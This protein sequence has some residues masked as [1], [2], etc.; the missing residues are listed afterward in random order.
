M[1]RD[2]T[3]IQLND[4]HGYLDIHQELFWAGDHA[5]YRL[6]GGHGRIA[7]LLKRAREEKPG[8]TLA[9]DCGDT[10]HGTYPAVQTEGEA[11]IPILNALDFEAMTSHWEFAY[12]PARLQEIAAQLPYPLLA[13]NCYDQ[14]TDELVFEPYTVLEAGG[15]RIGVIGIAATIVDKVMPAAFSEG[16][17]FTLGNEE[18]P[19]H[20][21]R[22][23]SDEGA[24][25]VLVVSHLGF[26][27]EVKLARE[28]DGIDICLSGHAHSRIY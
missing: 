10:I 20:V 3:I 11:L 18:L 9:F 19:G 15:L 12:G 14:E 13:V 22:L 28:V 25:L 6:A 5:E 16:V 1:T 8:A 2:L 23:R 7:T 17:Y 27:Q 26:P 4:S 24:D 21:E